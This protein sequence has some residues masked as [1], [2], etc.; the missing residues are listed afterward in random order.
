MLQ[1]KKHR[2]Y[3]GLISF[4]IPEGFFFDPVEG[5]DVL[6]TIRL[7][8]P[9]DSFTLELRIEKDC[10]GLE[11]ELASAIHDL[12]PAL[13]YPI[14]PLTINGLPGSHATYRCRRIQCYEAWFEIGEGTALSLII[15][16]HGDILDID[17]AALVAAVDP[18]NTPKKFPPKTRKIPVDKCTP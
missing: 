15:E 5:T 2:F 13:V 4:Q 17:T 3:W 11:L 1:Y 14:A 8:A 9:D 18:K 16:T 6:N 10:A 7:F 12:E